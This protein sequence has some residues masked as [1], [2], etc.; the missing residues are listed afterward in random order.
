MWRIAKTGVRP[1][2]GNPS[3]TRATLLAITAD[4]DPDANDQRIEGG[5]GRSSHETACGERLQKRFCGI[6][7]VSVAYAKVLTLP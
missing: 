1:R 6:D 3:V 5:V 4:P 2:T 7:R